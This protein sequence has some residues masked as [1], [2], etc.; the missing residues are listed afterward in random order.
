MNDQTKSLFFLATRAKLFMVAERAIGAVLGLGLLAPLI[1]PGHA[2][3]VALSAQVL[4]LPGTL[5]G[6]F[7]IAAGVGRR[8]PAGSIAWGG[9]FGTIWHSDPARRLAMILLAQRMFDGPK[10]V[11]I[12]KRLEQDAREIA[13]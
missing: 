6:V 4:A 3:V 1:W 9:G 7:T 2:A 13:G 12:F 11:T 8:L 10:P 5:V